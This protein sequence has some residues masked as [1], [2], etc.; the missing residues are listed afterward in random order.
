MDNYRIK[1]KVTCGV[2]YDHKEVYVV[3]GIR[4]G[5]LELEGDWSGGT[6]NTCQ[7]SWVSIGDCKLYEKTM[8]VG[9]LVWLDGYN[10][11]SQQN[12]Q[13]HYPIE[14]IDYKYDKNNGRKFPVYLVNGMWFDGRDGGGYD[15]EYLMYYI[16][17]I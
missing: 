4:E 8:I 6:H 14:D 1:D 7:R 13:K 2:G 10:S 17:I 5:E 3:S 9:D 16:E 11:F 12:S 15:D